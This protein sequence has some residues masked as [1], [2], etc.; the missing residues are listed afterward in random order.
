M[1]P[2]SYPVKALG[3]TGL[4]L[5]LT[6]RTESRHK[7]LNDEIH[8]SHKVWS[9]YALYS[10]TEFQLT[11]NLMNWNFFSLFVALDGGDDIL[12][13]NGT[14]TKH[15]NRHHNKSVINLNHS[16]KWLHFHNKT[17]CYIMCLL[18]IVLS[19]LIQ[20]L[21][22]VTNPFN[23]LRS[24][25]IY[26]KLNIHHSLWMRV[27]NDSPDWCWFPLRVSEALPIISKIFVFSKL[28]Q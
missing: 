9:H 3:S 10:L 20:P 22:K 23:S 6:G 27:L 4:G 8:V 19:F 28:E 21:K 1:Q 5:G 7:W 25:S 2:C 12:K 13:S 11:L 18:F 26:W 17:K 14:C 16:P 15:T 24:F